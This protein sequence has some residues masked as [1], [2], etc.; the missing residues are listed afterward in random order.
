[1]SFPAEGL[2]A[3]YRNDIHDVSQLLG[4]RHP[5]NYMVYNLTERHYD[6]SKFGDN[7]QAW[8]GWP[9]HHSPADHGHESRTEKDGPVA[10]NPL[11]I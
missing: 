3:T 5:G 10:K 4:Q 8:C 11:Y 9:D 7:V 1:M 6:Y 2:E